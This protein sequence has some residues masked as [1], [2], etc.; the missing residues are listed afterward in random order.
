M[1]LYER[2]KAQFFQQN[3]RL[4]ASHGG[5]RDP[6]EVVRQF[7]LRLGDVE[8]GKLRFGNGQWCFEYT[9]S[10][11]QLVQSGEM[12]EV[13]GFPDVQKFYTSPTLWPFFRIRLP[14]KYIEAELD[15]ELH[16]A[17]LLERYGRRTS[18]NPY[19]LASVG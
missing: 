1:N 8:V 10:Y 13:I 3:E 14:G 2:I 11:Q 12:N 16:E 17:E 4:P 6:G 19:E 9:A 5:R 15:Q 18:L 7:T